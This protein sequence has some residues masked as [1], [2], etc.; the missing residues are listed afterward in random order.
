MSAATRRA[1]VL[2]VSV[3][4]MAGIFAGAV[5]VALGGLQ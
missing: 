1:V 2:V 5:S 4:L 3:G